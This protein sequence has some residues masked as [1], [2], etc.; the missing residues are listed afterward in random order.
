MMSLSVKKHINRLQKSIQELQTN[1]EFVS[2]EHLDELSQNEHVSELLENSL[3]CVNDLNK[4]F[5]NYKKQEEKDEEKEKTKNLQKSMAAD[6][7]PDSLIDLDN[8]QNIPEEIENDLSF[9]LDLEEELQSELECNS[10][11]K[12]PHEPESNCSQI[13]DQTEI[14]SDFDDDD[15]NLFNEEFLKELDETEKSFQ[16][17]EDKENDEDDIEQPTDSK[18]LKVL[19]QYFGYS[20]FRP[21]QWQIINSVLNLKKDNC[22]IMATGHGKSLCYQFPSVFTGRTSVV[23]TPL[24]SLMQDQVMALSSASIPACY[25]GSSQVEKSKT[26]DGLLNG[27]YRLVYVTPEY[28]TTDTSILHSLNQRVGLDLIAIDEAHCVS[29]WGHDFRSAYRSLG[30]FRKKFSQVPVIALTATATPEVTKDICFSLN[31]KQPVVTCT[32][33]DRP[34]LYL[35]VCRKSGNIA[36]DLKKHMTYKNKTYSFENSTIIYCPTKKTTM[37]V[38]SVVRQIGLTCMPYHA[39]L[40]DKA[41]KEAHKE[42]INNKVQVVV[43]TIAFGMGI[44]KPD[45]RKVI[46]YGAPKDIESYYQEVGRAGRDGLPSSCHV[47][48]AP[49]DFNIYRFLMKDLKNQNFRQHKLSMISRMQNYLSTTSCRRRVLLSH[50]EKNLQHIGGSENCCDNC[51]KKIDSSQGIHHDNEGIR[52]SVI[53]DQ[54]VDYSKEVRILLEAINSLNGGFGLRSYTLFLM[55]SSDKKIKNFSSN[56]GYGSGKYKSAKFWI[57][58]A[59]SLIYENYLKEDPIPHGFGMIVSLSKKAYAWLH[60]SRQDN[61]VKFELVPSQ[62]MLAEEKSRV[63][64]VIVSASTSN[65]IE[66][67]SKFANSKTRVNDTAPRPVKPKVDERVE[68]LQNT[69]YKTLLKA[70]DDYAQEYGYL[71]HAI[72]SNKILLNMVTIRPKTKESMLKMEEFAE[73]KVEKYGQLFLDILIPFCHDNKLEMDNFICLESEQ[74]LS[75][76]MPEAVQS[77]KETQQV[78]YNMFMFENKSLEEIAA[79]RGL[80]TSTII[81]HMCAA[82]EAGAD[83]DIKRLGLPSSI[84][85]QITDTIHGPKI[86]NDVSRLTR[87]K[88]LLPEDVEFNHIKITISILKQQQG[89]TITPEGETI[90]NQTQNNTNTN[91]SQEVHF[92]ST[93]SSSKRKLPSSLLIDKP[94]KN[95]KSKSNFLLR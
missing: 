44:D 35:S 38:T 93:E 6:P 30:A 54:P 28:A 73:A 45:I 9:D 22:V 57:A 74:S 24:I 78:S 33:F 92:H 59:R 76:K 34:N 71:P 90:L 84:Q 82:I 91:D 89:Y 25:L 43:A 69:L 72:A 67:L 63:I 13:S 64:P 83:V 62:E 75:E 2:P 46:H 39:G 1:Y 12:V 94:F 65:K 14:L 20:K 50:F 40:P 32:G 95:K 53:H 7:G 77:L 23:I 31:L 51:R 79:L 29:Q 48:Y 66:T 41:R 60:E 19:K 56:E 81:I 3:N 61:G 47:F 4:V 8:Y 85:K 88:D 55:G 16:E 87:I 21:K 70:R 49:A 86:N 18:Y 37:E 52:N 5:Q 15:S 42:F 11:I 17:L 26:V 58:L 36:T 27:Q 68:A 10:E 80:K